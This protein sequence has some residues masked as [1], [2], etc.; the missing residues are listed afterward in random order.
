MLY[1]KADMVYHDYIWRAKQDIDDPN[2]RNHQESAELNRRE[3]YEMLYFI[4]YFAFRFHWKNV[5]K[6]TFQTIEKIIREE[7]PST[8][9]SHKN[10]IEWLEENK[11]A[12]LL[13]EGLRN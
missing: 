2:F 4:N 8:L 5:E 6:Q 9:R 1:K 13:L 7:V 3:G 10:I 12:W 11:K